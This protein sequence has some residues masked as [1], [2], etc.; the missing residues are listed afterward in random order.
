MNE[1]TTEQIEAKVSESIENNKS[2]TNSHILKLQARYDQAVGSEKIR[3]QA[4]IDRH[5]AYKEELDA[6]VINDLVNTSLSKQTERLN[7]LNLKTQPVIS[8]SKLPK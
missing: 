1:L 8:K 7:K 2:A 3:L 6:T 5:T 4:L